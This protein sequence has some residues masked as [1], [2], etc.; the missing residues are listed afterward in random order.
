MK[1]TFKLLKSDYFY[2]SD[3]FYSNK[4]WLLP[5]DIANELTAFRKVKDMPTGFYT[6]LDDEPR[7]LTVDLGSAWDSAIA[8]I[9]KSPQSGVILPTNKVLWNIPKTVIQA[10]VFED[11]EGNEYGVNVKYY[12]LIQALGAVLYALHPHKPMVA[13][14]GDRPV[15]VIMPYRL[16]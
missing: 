16:D 10:I 13:Y 12:A 8:D 14:R 2:V 3:T 4:H 6:T 7:E 11:S 1:P 5:R 9:N 15:A